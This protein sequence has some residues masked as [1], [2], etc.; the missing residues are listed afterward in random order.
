MGLINIRQFSDPQF[1]LQPG[2][3]PG[4]CF[5][6]ERSE[7]RIRIKLTRT[8]IITGVTLEHVNKNLVQDIGSAPK[9]FEVIVKLLVR[10]FL[11]YF[12]F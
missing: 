9:S 5:A 6:F 11:Y 10:L 4:Q 12:Q 3:L 7:G 8:I 2:I 1:L